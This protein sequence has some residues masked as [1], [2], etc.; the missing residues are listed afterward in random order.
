MQGPLNGVMFILAGVLN[1]IARNEQMFSEKYPAV[2]SG[3]IAGCRGYQ[4]SSFSLA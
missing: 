3:K 1:L 4:G 2:S